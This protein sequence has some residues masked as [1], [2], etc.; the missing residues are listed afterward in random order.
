[1]DD[2]ESHE[3]TLLI[4]IVGPVIGLLVGA[5]GRAFRRYS[6]RIQDSMGDVTRVT[7]Q[8]LQGQRVV[9]VFAGEQQE[10]AQFAALNERNFRLNIRL[11]ATRAAGDSLT[12][13]VV[14]VGVAAVIYVASRVGTDLR[15][16]DFIGYITAMGILLT[17]LKRVININAALQRGIAA[18]DSLFE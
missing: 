18:A 17:P 10:R 11:V 14:A 2:Q 9:K 15:A 5:M 13:F 3:L 12:Q 8:S 1:M 16:A 7:E 6:R 4:A